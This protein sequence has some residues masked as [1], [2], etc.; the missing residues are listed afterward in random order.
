[1]TSDEQPS[2][3]LP[4][5]IIE[6]I[7]E[8]TPALLPLARFAHLHLQHILSHPPDSVLFP[9]LH[10]L[11]G[12]NDAQNTFFASS[13]GAA[14]C[15]SSSSSGTT[16][17]TTKPLLNKS[18]KV[19]RY[20][21]LVWVVCEDD[22]EA[23]P[24]RYA[25]ELS[26]LLRK[27]EGDNGG[28]GTPV[29][30]GDS[31]SG[32][33]S[34]LDDDEDD[35]DVVSPGEGVAME[36]KVDVVPP[37]VMD[38]DGDVPG[39]G[40]AIPFD[41]G[42][43]QKD[44]EK[45]MHPVIQRPSP[46]QTANLPSAYSI[47]S[48]LNTSLTTSDSESFLFTPLSVSPS[49]TPDTSQSDTRLP[50]STPTEPNSSIVLPTSAS[51]PTA[52][53]ESVSAPVP[54]LA[55]LT[56]TFRPSEI[57][58]PVKRAD[59][60]GKECWEFVP[61]KVPEGISLRNFGIQVPIYT[62]L[63]DIVVYSPKGPSPKAQVLAQR[64]QQAIQR[65]YQ[66][67]AKRL[68]GTLTEGGLFTHPDLLHYNVFI[69][70][71]T[72]S[73]MH[74]NTG[75]PH[76]VMRLCVNGV[77]GSGPIGP[78]TKKGND[79]VDGTPLK[80]GASWGAH[81]DGP[82]GHI[83]DMDVIEDP[84]AVAAQG[85]GAEGMYIDVD[86][87]MEIEMEP[88]MDVDGGVMRVLGRAK[89][90]AKDPNTVDFS[91]REKE[92]M[93]DLTKASEII[94]VPPPD[95]MEGHA[96][97]VITSPSTGTGC[98]P[99]PGQPQPPSVLSLQA[100]SPT[101]W[102]PHVGQVFLGN[103]DD[104]PL[105]AEVSNRIHSAMNGKESRT[106][107]NGQQDPFDYLSTNDPA[108]GFGFDICIECHDL[109]PFPTPAA[110]RTA[111][112]H[113]MRLDDIWVK[114]LMEKRER[115]GKGED[116]TDIIPPRPP[117]HANAVIHLPFPS[118]PSNSQTS[119]NAL[120][121]VIR[122]L[123]KWLMPVVPPPPPPPQPPSPGPAT[124]PS[125]SPSRRWSSVASLM[126][127]FPSFPLTSSPSSSLPLQAVPRTRSLTSPAASQSNS[128]LPHAHVRTRPVKV[129][130]Y[131]A[132]GYTESSLL[133]LCLLMAVKNL[134][135][136]EAYLELQVARRRSFFVYHADLGLLRR[137]ESRLREDYARERERAERE[138][139][140]ARGAHGYGLGHECER[141]VNGN[142]KRV[143]AA[144]VAVSSGPPTARSGWGA[145]PENGWGS[146]PSPRA[147][148][149]LPSNSQQQPTNS[150]ANTQAQ[151]V[152]HQH[153][154]TPLGRP[155]AKS[156]SFGHAA[157]PIPHSQPLGVPPPQ[158]YGQD[159]FVP[160]TVPTQ[161]PLPMPPKGRPRANTSPWLPSV[162][163]DHH[164]WFNDPRFDGSF[165]SRVLP[166]LY[167]GNFLSL[168]HAELISGAYRNHAANAFMLHALG[169][170][171]VVS[172][173]E[174][175]LIPP[176]HHVQGHGHY[177]PPTYHHSGP[178]IHGKG[179][180]HGSLWYEEREGR[181]KVLDIKGVCDDGIDTLEPQ[182]EPI[183]DWIDQARAEGGQ[184]LVHCRVG[185][186]RSATVTRLL[187]LGQI[188]YVMKHLGLPLVDAY[189]IVRSRRLSVLIQ[190]NMRLLY[191]LCG[192]EIKLAKARAG[193][194]EENLRNELARTLSWPYLAKEVHALNEKY[195]H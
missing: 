186:S 162:S 12:D 118:S 92:E 21:G 58:Q 62:T 22:L 125:T 170:T 16:T 129:L 113:L 10:G 156:V 93:R 71:A 102:T 130:L 112:E 173:G 147:I 107:E 154:H 55:L 63:S 29:L 77:P 36:T 99:H 178:F 30:E 172:V 135:L 191:N 166:F 35:E 180:G 83:V 140:R 19:P 64:I 138:R 176:P 114:G 131:S 110:L 9:F 48:D 185:V 149:P 78:G 160:G 163:G 108:K 60:G 54:D 98:G 2:Y 34:D 111:E 157:S 53:A 44:Q 194:S 151:P 41:D 45:H 109:A 119:T 153:A 141:E 167:L 165:P 152:P 8:H 76:L 193:D 27:R 33:S 105:V 75:I 137:V 192:W 187:L 4:E 42:A 46:I 158:T 97:H 17:P 52:T 50:L 143:A 96:N 164:S 171:H 59:N 5:T 121:A 182:L 161:H 155:A 188:A 47:S 61:A 127:H 37:D 66:E 146:L 81:T 126:P 124:A 11:E 195:L 106:V 103:S 134:S 70:D 136:P 150:H 177:A 56:C 142:G 82:D 72:A 14:S 28:L 23:E 40:E 84:M 116:S 13:S 91:Q 86:S 94:S 15:L 174:C 18:A 6:P 74:A 101:V 3:G 115:E 132:D 95:G 184:V 175:A 169:I 85:L 104:V 100:L 168:W 39:H 7:D 26:L 189:L 145:V 69:L 1:M 90:H 122:L 148:L 65:K 80:D 190:P 68:G 79:P 139:E 32:A 20:R 133:A 43:S 49:L 25:R 57:V 183:C 179:P 117:P 38:I 120:I 31:E 181:I 24:R 87:D 128:C 88:G 159:R 89:A 144:A 67:R 51:N 73:D 123:E